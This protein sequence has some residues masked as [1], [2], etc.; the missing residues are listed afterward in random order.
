MEERHAL[1]GPAPGLGQKRRRDGDQSPGRSS[2]TGTL[3]RTPGHGTDRRNGSVTPATGDATKNWLA[4]PICS[5][6]LGKACPAPIRCAILRHLLQRIDCEAGN[7]TV[8]FNAAGIKT[9]AEELAQ[10]ETNP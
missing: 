2:A 7:I 8:T 3:W 1:L 9:L 10:Q 4:L 6:V 5:T